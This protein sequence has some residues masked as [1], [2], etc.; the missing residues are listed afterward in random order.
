MAAGTPTIVAKKK[1]EDDRAAAQ[2][3]SAPSAPAEPAERF[4]AADK[5]LKDALGDDFHVVDPT[6]EAGITRVTPEGSAPANPYKS[7]GSSLFDRFLGTDVD[8]PIPLTRMGTEILGGFAGMTGGASAGAT[9]GG[10]IG[11]AIEPGGGT[12]VG[13]GIG[14]GIGGLLGSAAGTSLGG[15]TPEAVLK[16][17][18]FMGLVTPE[19]AKQHSLNMDDLKTVMKGDALLDMVTGGALMAGRLAWRPLVR[20]FTKSGGKDARQ[21]A[22]FAAKNGVD[23]LPIQLGDTKIP[24]G[25]VAVMGKFPLVGAPISKRIIKSDEAF[26]DAF[27]RLPKEIA[28]LAT[29]DE[30]SKRVIIDAQ[31]KFMDVTRDFST[32][33]A[34]IF[35]NA[36]N[37]GIGVI[38]NATIESATG[39]LQQ[40]EKEIPN[41]AG[42]V[43]GGMTDYMRETKNFIE[44]D[45]MPVVRTT[46]KGN[47]ETSKQTMTQ[48]NT[49]LEMVDTKIAKLYKE[50]SDP[51]VK[52]AKRLED[53][54]LSVQQDMYVNMKGPGAKLA[55]RDLQ[56][57]D[58]QYSLTMNSLF[59][60]TKG[61][62]RLNLLR[63]GLY[64]QGG[65][66]LPD[67][68][69]LATTLMKDY[70]PRSLDRLEQ[71][72]TP[73]SFKGLAAA[74]LDNTFSNFGKMDANGHRFLDLQGLKKELGIGNPD[75][76]RYKYFSSMLQ[77][78]GGLTMDQLDTFLKVGERIGSVEAPNASTFI[79][80]RATMGGLHAIATAFL[81]MASGPAMGSGGGAIGA[82]I[83]GLVTIGGPRFV[84]HMLTDPL[85][86]RYLTQVMKPEVSKIAR[87]KAFL[88]LVHLTIDGMMEA[89]YYT[90]DE[91]MNLYHSLE[92][93]HKVVD[94]KLEESDT[95]SQVPN[96]E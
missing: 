2:Q 85:A 64:G 46:A 31:D 52:M 70:D 62:K 37:A 83:G 40:I 74:K 65:D 3:Q 72:M 41:V 68:E 38:P 53:L 24:R 48:M 29:M 89:G 93:Y 32:K 10:A 47:I 33:R 82:L 44:R 27:T 57:L 23:M 6:K 76:A 1:I 88:G 55:G 9:I 11:S 14:A 16:G 22:D 90:A 77:K 49:M 63:E 28:P 92:D 79:A 69:R 80:R 71:L 96:S 75:S 54:K 30:M 7:E 39:I 95:G 15:A 58:Q 13:A 59:R 86:A 18:E 21:L 87:K 66:A 94:K 4:S 56:E 45:I 12:A 61:G 43:K 25:F 81:P 36:D 60:S 91:G 67:V 8:D 17:A 84:G 20:A 51:A 42:D 34:Q 35:K 78:S 5:E 73:E 26:K 19:Y 50:G